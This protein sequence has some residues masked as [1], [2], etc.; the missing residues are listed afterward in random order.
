M[1]RQ[2]AH[3]HRHLD[4]TIESMADARWFEEALPILHQY[5]PITSILDVGCRC[6]ASLVMMEDLLPDAHIEG[7]DVVPEFIEVAMGRGVMAHLAD[8]HH[9]PF[10]HGEFQW[11]T[12]VG[13]FE[14]FYNSHR[15]LSEIARVSKEG[16]YVTCDLR[17]APLASDYAYSPDTNA[18]REVMESSTMLVDQE[19]IKDGHVLFVLRRR[20]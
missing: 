3:N 5:G 2:L 6:G 8:A 14:H 17:D 11:V 7:V 18:W 1:E 12:C 4:G 15:A 20:G 13:T 10:M 19:I 9:L 16:V